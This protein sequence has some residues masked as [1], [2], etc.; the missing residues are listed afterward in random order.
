MSYRVRSFFIHHLHRFL[1]PLH[2]IGLI[3]KL[4]LNLR[5][6]S[7]FLFIGKY[8]IDHWELLCSVLRVV[9]YA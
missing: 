4:R 7:D 3:L 8:F 1:S 5:H 2:L 9:T 6:F